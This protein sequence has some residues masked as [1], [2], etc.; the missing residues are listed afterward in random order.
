MQTIIIN[1]VYLL[2]SGCSVYYPQIR[3]EQCGYKD[4]IEYNIVHKDFVFTDSEPKSEEEF[5]DDNDDRD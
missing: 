5:N 3:L 4:F 2:C 1:T